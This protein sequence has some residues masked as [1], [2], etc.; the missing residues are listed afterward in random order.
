MPNH[1]VLPPPSDRVIINK[2]TTT[3]VDISL[4]SQ[5]RT[6]AMQNNVMRAIIGIS[7]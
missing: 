1:H 3:S 5:H 2:I 6:S 4:D 7:L